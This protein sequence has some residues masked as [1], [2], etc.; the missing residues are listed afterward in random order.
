R[1]FLVPAALHENSQ[2]IAVLIHCSPQV[3]AFAINRKKYLIT[4]IGMD[5]IERPAK[6]EAIE[7]LRSDPRT[8]QQ[9]ERFVGKKLGS[10]RQGAIGKPQ[11]IE[12]HPGHR[13]ARCN[14]LLVIRNEASVDH[15]Y[16]AK[17]FYH[18]GNEPSMI[19]A[20]HM[21]RCHYCPFPESAR[22]SCRSLQRKVKD[23]FAFFTC[24]MSAGR[25]MHS[26]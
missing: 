8:K 17:V 14:L 21:D 11:A 13:F 16:Q 1:G 10:E 22:V 5:F 9:I 15:A 20:F 7:H 24:S 23:F 19:Q 12:D 26:D 2:H 4:P 18:T 3:V 25:D 6:L